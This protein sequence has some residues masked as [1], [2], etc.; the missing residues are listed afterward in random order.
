MA[1]TG[2]M[3]VPKGCLTL[4]L[5]LNVR[6]PLSTFSRAHCPLSSAE[7]D[8]AVDAGTAIPD[9]CEMHEAFQLLPTF[10]L[11]QLAAWPS[12]AMIGTR[13]GRTTIR[14]SFAELTFKRCVLTLLWVVRC[15]G[16]LSFWCA[17]SVFWGAVCGL[18]VN[19]GYLMYFKGSERIKATVAF[20]FT[21]CNPLISIFI[22]A[23]LCKFKHFS[24]LQWRYLGASIS[25]YGL[26]IGVLSQ[27]LE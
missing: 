15:G 24:K 13:I 10:A 21:A 20:C 17:F 6:S 11:G 25:L 16:S 2:P 4:I 18:I 5:L 8:V 12:V 7:I 27:C 9:S 3:R 26:A 22:D 19:S 1:H 14:E 23:S